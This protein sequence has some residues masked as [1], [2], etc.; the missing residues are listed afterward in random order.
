MRVS[1]CHVAAGACLVLLAAFPAQA[2]DPWPPKVG[3]SADVKM[4]MGKGPDGKPMIAKGKVYGTPE[5]NTRREITGQMAGQKTV[6]IKR[7][8]E[9]VTLTLI[10]DKRIYWKSRR[11]NKKDPERMIREGNAKI[12]PL[13]S[14]TINGIRARKLRIE[15][16]KNNRRAVFHHWVTKDNVPV[17]MESTKGRYFRIDYKNIKIGKQ[18]RRLFEIPA[19]YRLVSSPGIPTLSPRGVKPGG[20]MPQGLPP[21]MT[22]EQ[23]E[24]MR[25]QMEEVMKQLQKQQG[26]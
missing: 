24:Q 20:K 13:G 11:G 19:N 18:D 6:I 3:Y 16:V 8:K 21:G 5:G 7:P 23:A 22:K 2:G 10:P 4:N 9:N 1:W 14:E 12:T 15:V 25:K 26:R 17:R